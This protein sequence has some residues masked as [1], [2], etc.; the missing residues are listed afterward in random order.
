MTVKHIVDNLIAVGVLVKKESSNPDVERNPK[1]LE[2]A[3]NYGNIVCVNL[4][5][6]DEIS[7][8][9]YD[10]YEHLIEERSLMLNEEGA[11]QEDLI[12]A[13]RMISSELE[14]VATTTVD[15]AVFV[16]SAYWKRLYSSRLL[17]SE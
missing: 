13:L 6:K 15:V 10:I 2:I 5:S 4:T 1:V 7:F 12:E 3:E 11:Y 16:P 9:I 14:I 17:K 8:L